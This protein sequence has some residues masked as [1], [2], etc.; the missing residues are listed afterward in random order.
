[1]RAEASVGRE[2]APRHAVAEPRPAAHPRAGQGVRKPGAYSGAKAKRVPSSGG[3][4]VRS[5]AV[6][7]PTPSAGR[8]SNALP[9]VRVSTL[10]T[11]L[12]TRTA[13][14]ASAVVPRPVSYPIRMSPAIQGATG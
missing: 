8:S 5:T 12:V 1:V 3:S 9:V 13:R 6:E 7:K 4:R 2:Q 11:R 14:S 10:V